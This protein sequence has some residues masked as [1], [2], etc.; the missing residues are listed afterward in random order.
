M[1]GYWNSKEKNLTLGEY[2]LS[3]LIMIAFIIM[4]DCDLSHKIDFN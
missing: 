3:L 1:R 4:L 2:Y